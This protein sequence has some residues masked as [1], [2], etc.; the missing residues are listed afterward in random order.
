[1]S[2]QQIP[3]EPASLTANVLPFDWQEI[4]DAAELLRDHVEVSQYQRGWWC[5]YRLGPEDGNAPVAPGEP[6]AV[7]L[8]I[9]RRHPGVH[10]FA[11]AAEKFGRGLIDDA[12]GQMEP[13]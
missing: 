8:C 13:H 3:D 5:T 9:D 6:M 12:L 11:M 1:M 4:A 2:T 7:V 10:L